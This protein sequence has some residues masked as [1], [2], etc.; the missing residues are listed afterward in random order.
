MFLSRFPSP[1]PPFES[2]LKMQNVNFLFF[3]FCVFILFDSK[4]GGQ[5]KQCV[6]FSCFRWGGQNN[7]TCVGLDFFAKTGDPKQRVLFHFGSIVVQVLL[8]YFARPGADCESEL[9]APPSTASGVAPARTNA[10]G[11][12][13]IFSF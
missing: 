11:I 9:F 2:D 10:A 1:S 13:P 4:G 12:G 7:E 6:S 3:I 8:V 5:G